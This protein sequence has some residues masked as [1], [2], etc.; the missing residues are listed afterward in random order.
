[1]RIYFDLEGSHISA[2]DKKKCQQLWP[3]TWSSS[4]ALVADIA[5]NRES[6]MA[7]AGTL[8]QLGEEPKSTRLTIQFEADENRPPWKPGNRGGNPPRRTA[9]N[10][11]PPA[12]SGA[13]ATPLGGLKREPQ[14][15][16]ET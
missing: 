4:N 9:G 2:F 16:R 5:Y 11:N 14:I 13:N 12:P 8:L 10:R 1:M 7:L 6:V 3:R 15:K